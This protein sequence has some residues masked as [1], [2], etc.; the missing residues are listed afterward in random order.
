[1]S[2]SPCRF[3]S[4]HR[5]ASS[6]SPP[7]R[8]I[9]QTAQPIKAKTT[10]PAATLIPM[11]APV[12]IVSP[13]DFFAESDSVAEEAEASAVRIFVTTLTEPPSSVIVI[14]GA[15]AEVDGDTEV[16]GWAEDSALEE[17]EERTAEEAALDTT[18]LE[19][20]A[21][22]VTAEEE[23][24]K[25]VDAI[26]LEMTEGEAITEARVVDGDGIADDMR[27]VPRVVV[28]VAEASSLPTNPPIIPPL[29]PESLS[30]S[31][32]AVVVDPLCRPTKGA[33]LPFDL[34]PKRSCPAGCVPIWRCARATDDKTSGMKRMKECMVRVNQRMLIL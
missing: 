7:L 32:A 9:L 21:L 12:E 10:T 27:T 30:S 20:D 18:L 3:N 34:L 23:G 6:S 14:T 15:L 13:P 28:A 4:G 1:M 25:D 16:D 29:L 26:T 11:M 19:A 33:Y 8:F 5:I 31:P 24:S 2:E 22:E 17:V